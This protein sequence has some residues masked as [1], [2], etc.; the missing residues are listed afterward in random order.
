MHHVLDPRTG[1][2]AEPVWRTVSV[3]AATCEDAN[4]LTTAAIVRGADAAL[5][6]RS[7]GLPARLV[8]ADGR[9]VTAGG[10]PST[11]EARYERGPS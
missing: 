11:S 4:T 6:L 10:W 5:W 8:R 7:F 9:V 1:A 2:P 3:A